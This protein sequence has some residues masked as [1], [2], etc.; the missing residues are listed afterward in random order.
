L[1]TRRRKRLVL[2]FGPVRCIMIMATHLL[3]YWSK[4][5]MAETCWVKARHED[6]EEE[7]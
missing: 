6:G 2:H 7:R 5:A 3:H 4:E 1:T